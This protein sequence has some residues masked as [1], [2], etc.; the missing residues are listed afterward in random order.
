MVT[1]KRR[2][3]THETVV[4]A[5]PVLQATARVFGLFHTEHDDHHDEEE[6]C[7]RELNTIDAEI[8]NHFV[9]RDLS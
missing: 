6:A 8:A 5:L 4:D 7:Q 2:C 3:L 1:H 9:A